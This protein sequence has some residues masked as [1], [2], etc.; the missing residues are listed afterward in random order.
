MMCLSDHPEID[1]F[2]PHDPT[3]WAE[4]V[5]EY[6]KRFRGQIDL[7]EILN[8]PNIRAGRRKNPDPAKYGEITP[9]LQAKYIDVLRSAIK[10]NDPSA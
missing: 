7:Y 5:S 9:A 8:E 4:K 2:L 10:K 1:S 6:A 3:S